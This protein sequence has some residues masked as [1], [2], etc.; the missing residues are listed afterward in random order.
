MNSSSG[1]PIV[2]AI[3]RIDEDSRQPSGI[4]PSPK[5]ATG[6]SLPG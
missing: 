2:E 5:G 6:A 3:E 4:S 1:T